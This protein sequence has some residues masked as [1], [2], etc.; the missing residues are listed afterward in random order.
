MAKR[1]RAIALRDGKA[2]GAGGGDDVE[3]LVQAGQRLAAASQR[4]A[5]TFERK[6]ELLA[7]FVFLHAARL[8]HGLERKRE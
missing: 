6:S 1:P 4:F 7:R 8:E 5:M 2:S 3:N